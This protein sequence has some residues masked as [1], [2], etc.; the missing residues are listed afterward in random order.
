L[1]VI[2]K[3]PDQAIKTT[4]RSN[5]FLHVIGKHALR[6]ANIPYRQLQVSTTKMVQVLPGLI[7]NNYRATYVQHSS[8]LVFSNP[9][10]LGGIKGILLSE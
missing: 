5:Q 8:Q 7:T 6:T 1:Y 10:I 4:K 3:P 9:I 2:C